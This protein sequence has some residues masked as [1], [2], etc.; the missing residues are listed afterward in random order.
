MCLSILL[1]NVLSVLLELVLNTVVDHDLNL[2]RFEEHKLIT[3]VDCNQKLFPLLREI[4]I[5]LEFIVDQNIIDQSLQ[6]STFKIL[7]VPGQK[8]YLCESHNQLL[9]LNYIQKWQL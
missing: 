1:Q 3:F 4:K 6:S 2:L 7:I 9:I 5:V 8:L